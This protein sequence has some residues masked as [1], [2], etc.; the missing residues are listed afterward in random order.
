M[1]NTYDGTLVQQEDR[2]YA[3]IWIEDNLI[4]Y[5]LCLESLQYCR[6]LSDEQFYNLGDV[7]F[8]LINNEA[9]IVG[10]QTRYYKS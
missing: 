1:S 8:K 2:I 4:S 3:E 6:S 9:I 5:P 7:E 10:T